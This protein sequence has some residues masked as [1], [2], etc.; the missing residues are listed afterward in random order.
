LFVLFRFSGD[1]A[2]IEFSFFGSCV[3]FHAY[4]IYYKMFHRGLFLSVRLIWRLPT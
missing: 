3:P 2:I 1:S 4:D